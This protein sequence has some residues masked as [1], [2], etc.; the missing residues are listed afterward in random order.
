MTMSG[1]YEY[2]LV[3]ERKVSIILCVCMHTRI[4]EWDSIKLLNQLADFMKF[5][6]SIMPL[7]TTPISNFLI[8]YN[9]WWSQGSWVSRVTRLLVGQLGF[10][11]WQGEGFLC[12]LLCRDRLCGPLSFLS[13]GNGVAF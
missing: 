12:S 9:Q 11:S 13:V 7:E 6:M 8:L 4:C 2:I 1:I 3:D 10:N 5:G